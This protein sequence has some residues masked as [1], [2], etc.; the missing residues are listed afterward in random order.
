MNRSFLS[1]WRHADV[2]SQRRMSALRNE[3]SVGYAA[4]GLN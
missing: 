4:L 1:K 2:L 3:I